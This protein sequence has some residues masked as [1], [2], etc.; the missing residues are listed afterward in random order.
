MH[1]YLIGDLLEDLIF[2]DLGKLGG[3]WHNWGTYGG[4]LCIYVEVFAL[5]HF[6][7][8]HEHGAFRN[9]HTSFYNLIANDSQTPLIWPLVTPDTAHEPHLRIFVFAASATF[10]LF[11]LYYMILWGEANQQAQMTQKQAK[12]KTP[13]PNKKV[14]AH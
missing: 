10:G 3:L 6:L 5:N 12:P 2:R 14:K 9:P 11:T 7:T 13:E 1:H 4:A 8:T